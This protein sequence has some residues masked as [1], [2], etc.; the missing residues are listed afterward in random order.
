[1]NKLLKVLLILFVIGYIVSP[2]DLIPG[3]IAD[4]LI[5]LLMSIAA[6]RELDY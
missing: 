1:M 6:G 3:N 5:I 4:D 2:I